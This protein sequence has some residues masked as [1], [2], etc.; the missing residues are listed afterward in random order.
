MTLGESPQVL[1]L[2]MLFA[3][4]NPTLVCPEGDWTASGGRKV[5]EGPLNEPLGLNWREPAV[6]PIAD[7]AAHGSGAMIVI[8]DRLSKRALADCAHGVLGVEH[9]AQ[10]S[11]RHA[12]AV[13]QSSGEGAL[14]VHPPNQFPGI[15]ACFAASKVAVLAGGSAREVTYR[16]CDLAAMAALLWWWLLCDSGYS[17]CPVAGAI[18]AAFATKAG[19][20]KPVAWVRMER[21]EWL[22]QLASGAGFH[23]RNYSLALSDA[24]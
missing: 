12:V 13:L 17:C 3:L 11:R 14:W 19:N 21:I 6:A 20:P 10:I 22:V 2:L 1:V 8:N 16:F 4:I 5:R 23:C 9:R 7:Q 15:L 24:A 18:G